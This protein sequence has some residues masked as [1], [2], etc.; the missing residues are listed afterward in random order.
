[1]KLWD[2]GSHTAV[3]IIC[4]LIFQRAVVH[5]T[6]TSGLEVAY[7]GLL[8]MGWWLQCSPIIQT[9][10]HKIPDPFPVHLYLILSLD[11]WFPNIL[12]LWDVYTCRFLC[13]WGHPSF[14]C[15]PAN[16]Y[17]FFE[18]QNNCSLIAELP[19]LPSGLSFYV[20]NTS[21]ML[22]TAGSRFSVLG[23]SHYSGDLE[24]A[25]SRECWILPFALSSPFSTLL[26][27]LG[28]WPLQTALVGFP[29]PPASGGIC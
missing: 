19:I 28:G 20:A 16:S 6:H 23:F 10:P 2:S 12:H 7:T 21:M 3:L 18:I 1:M 17:S 27:A 5:G 11:W 22:I 14:S 4:S 13:P 9:K 26:Q 25:P 8:N 15:D 29:L 24:G